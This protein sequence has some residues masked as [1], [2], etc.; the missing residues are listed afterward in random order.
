MLG[1]NACASSHGSEKIQLY[2]SG[3]SLLT[4]VNRVS[5][6]IHDLCE[7]KSRTLITPSSP[8]LWKYTRSLS[9]ISHTDISWWPSSLA[10][11]CTQNTRWIIENKMLGRLLTDIY[12]YIY[13]VYQTH[14][15]SVWMPVKRRIITT[16]TNIKS[17]TNYISL[18]TPP[19]LSLYLLHGQMS[20]HKFSWS[21]EAAR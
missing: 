10:H 17:L 21:I 18:I 15:R 19:I 16:V 9:M 6:H 11:I 3:A 1:P 8:I 13:T 20:N 7:M 12:I 2:G 4:W 14:S 5:N